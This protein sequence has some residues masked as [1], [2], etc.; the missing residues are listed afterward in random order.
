MHLQPHAPD[1]DTDQG[2]D[3]EQL[4]PDGIHLRLGPLGAPRPSPRV[5]RACFT[6]TPKH[7]AEKVSAMVHQNCG[8][9]HFSL[10]PRTPRLFARDESALS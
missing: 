2:A 9:A 7:C 5:T 10:T 1:A 6:S 3:L 8:R 4:E